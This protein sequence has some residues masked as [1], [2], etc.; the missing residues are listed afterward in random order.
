[1][2]LLDGD[3]LQCMDRGGYFRVTVPEVNWTEGSPAG[4]PQVASNC[5]PVWLENAVDVDPAPWSEPAKDPVTV[6]V[7]PLLGSVN[8]RP[9]EG[10]DTPP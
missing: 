1:M 3:S 5:V 2:D 10:L 7:P 8:P 9:P 4:D 6:A